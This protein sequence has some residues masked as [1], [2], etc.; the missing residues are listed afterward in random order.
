MGAPK[1]VD[2]PEAA[3]PTTKERV[4][5]HGLKERRGKRKDRAVP[6]TAPGRDNEEGAGLRTVEDKQGPEKSVDA[7]AGIVACRPPFPAARWRPDT[8]LLS[9]C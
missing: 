1:N 9:T 8:R 3:D 2:D 5:I 4:Q 6:K 7:H